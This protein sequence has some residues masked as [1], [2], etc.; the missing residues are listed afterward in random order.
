MHRARIAATC[1]AFAFASSAAAQPILVA[2]SGDSAWVMSASLIALV[3]VLVGAASFHAALARL[4]DAGPALMHA[5]AIL[6]TVSLLWATIGYSLVFGDGTSWLGGIGNA[7]LANLAELRDGATISE[8]LFALF[9][10]IPAFLASALILGFFA[11]RVRFGWVVGFTALWSLLVYVPVARWVWG[12]GWLAGLGTLDT[13]GGLVVHT[14]AG[15]AALVVALMLRSS[16]S[17]EPGPAQPVLVGAALLFV[18]SLALSG[19]AALAADTDAASAIVNTLLATSAAALIWISMQRLVDGTVS[20][21]GMAAGAVTGLATVAPAAAFIGPMGAILLGTMGGLA[22]CAAASFFRR[23]LGGIDGC[24]VFAI[25]GVGGI[26][27]SLAF[28][29]FVLAGFGGPG[30]DEGASLSGQFVAQG[31]AVVV[32]VLWSAVVTPIVALMVSMV[33]PM[34]TGD[35]DAHRVSRPSGSGR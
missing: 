10:L 33:I 21:S 22:G 2:D 30:Y 11:Q 7:G 32:I 16:V 17:D 28:P 19:G 35:A 9:Q 26:V 4:R 18:G 5:F 12:G 23:A 25:H 31:T 27:G 20:A 34:R 29:L 6:C 1:F 13:A 24:L 8:P 14:T 15:V 3:A